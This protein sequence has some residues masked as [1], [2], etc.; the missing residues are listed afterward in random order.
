MYPSGDIAGYIAR[1]ISILNAAKN[2]IL[3]YLLRLKIK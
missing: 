1:I 2:K 3:L